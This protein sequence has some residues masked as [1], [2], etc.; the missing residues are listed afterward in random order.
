MNVE[1]HRGRSSDDSDGEQWQPR[2]SGFGTVSTKQGVASNST[3]PLCS[4]HLLLSICWLVPYLRW[5]GFI[6]EI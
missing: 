2:S 5:H 4:V 3:E 6:F 1:D